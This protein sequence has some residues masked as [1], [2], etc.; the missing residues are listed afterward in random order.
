MTQDWLSFHLDG[1]LQ[2]MGE[3]E[4]IGGIFSSNVFPDWY[5]PFEWLILISTIVEL[6]V[7]LQKPLSDYDHKYN[8]AIIE[9]YYILKR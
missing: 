8:E 4:G 2:T 3:V 9:R 7:C 5:C 1:K 6:K